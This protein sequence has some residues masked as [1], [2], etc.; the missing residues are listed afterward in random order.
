MSAQQSR[1]ILKRLVSQAG[2]QWVGIQET[3][4]PEPHVLLFNSPA[5]GSTLAI[6]LEPDM[7]PREIIEAIQKRLAAS[8]QEFLK[9]KKNVTTRKTE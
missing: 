2:A 4:P 9:G 5:T 7:A 8:N 1:S 3:V 6:H